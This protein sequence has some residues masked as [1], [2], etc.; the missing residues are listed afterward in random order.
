MAAA[1]TQQPSGPWGQFLEGFDSGDYDFTDSRAESL[2]KGSFLNPR[3]YGGKFR[4]GSLSAQ[5]KA[6]YVGGRVAHDLLTDGT[7][8]PYWA[9]NHPLAMTGAAGE[10]ATGLAG[11]AP[12]YKAEY[13]QRA[14]D[15]RDTSKGAIDAEFARRMGFS[16]R[17]KGAGVPL[18]L[19][20]VAIPALAAAAMT[21]TSNNT[22]YTNILNGGRTAGFQ[23][24]MPSPGGFTESSNPLVEL[25]ARYVFGRTGRVLPWEAF[26]SER[27]DVSKED[28]DN[29]VRYQFDGGPLGI[30][31]VRST[32]RNLDAEPE[33][34]MMG[35]RV[36][37]SA[38]S[39]AGGALVGAALGAR[40]AD[41]ALTPEMRQRLYLEQRGPR[42]LAGAMVGGL[43]GAVTGNFGSKVVN[44]AIIQPAFNPEQVA[45][46]AAWKQLS[47]Q[48]RLD[49]GK[50][51]PPPPAAA[52]PPSGKPAAAAAAAEERRRRQQQQQPPGPTNTLTETAYL[53]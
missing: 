45:E 29:Y 12:D 33:L 4:D 18:A 11:L 35:F 9:L 14:A 28:Y 21:A 23:S 37:L 10:V 34:Q 32:S 24:V 16:H 38:A 2:V 50:K 40:R 22:D 51:P 25:A 42:R 19:A 13:S 7:R 15:K 53:V 30:G 47:P 6:A 1:G 39:A 41:E 36:P 5:E 3:G 52:A 27:P 48:E 20:G 8:L 46:T 26:T 17:G 31:L 43:L 44:A 49:G